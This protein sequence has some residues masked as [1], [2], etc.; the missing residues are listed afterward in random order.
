VEL[1]WTVA[2][3]KN[4]RNYQLQKSTD[5]RTFN[6]I[7]DLAA[8]NTDKQHDYV[9]TDRANPGRSAFYRLAITGSDN[10]ISTSA[11]VEIKAKDALDKIYVANSS[12]L[13]AEIKF[14]RAQSVT[15]GIFN[16]NGQL[17]SSTRQAV[18]AGNNRLSIGIGGLQKGLYFLKVM[19]DG[20]D[21]KARSFSK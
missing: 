4:I 17:L 18:G 13:V 10:F 19:G 6:R 1:K 15:L 3:E 12:T 5:G 2:E 7:F 8:D 21:N 16:A 9:F 14:E 20:V 11:V